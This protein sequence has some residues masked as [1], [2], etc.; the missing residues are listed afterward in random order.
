MYSLEDHPCF[1]VFN[2]FLSAFVPWVLGAAS[3]VYY[4][5]REEKEQEEKKAQEEAQFVRLSFCMNGPQQAWTTR[6]EL[7][8]K[9]GECGSVAKAIASIAGNDK[10]KVECEISDGRLISLGSVLT[11]DLA[12]A[13]FMDSNEINVAAL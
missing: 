12:M 9:A 6:G 2:C 10:I 11:E 5:S 13:I 4:I 1:L 8:A 7:A 3:T